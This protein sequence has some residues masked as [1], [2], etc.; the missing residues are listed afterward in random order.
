MTIYYAVRRC[1]NYKSKKDIKKN[2]VG[3]ELDTLSRALSLYHL[4]SNPKG[5]M[6]KRPNEWLKGR[7]IKRPND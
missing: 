6:T 4:K 7:V 3:D 5:Q 1:C 2:C